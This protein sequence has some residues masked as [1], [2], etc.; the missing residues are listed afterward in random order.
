MN[1]P[2]AGSRLPTKS[3]FVNLTE[4]VF[5]DETVAVNTP[6]DGNIPD[7]TPNATQ[8]PATAPET[9]IVNS[10]LDPASTDGK[11][12]VALLNKIGE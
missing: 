9:V 11:L 6:L 7:G 2:D 12:R 10:A 4:T 8:S 3:V 5:E 1:K